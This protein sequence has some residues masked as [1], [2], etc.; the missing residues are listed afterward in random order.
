MCIRDSIEDALTRATEPLAELV[1]KEV[2]SAESRADASARTATGNVSFQVAA[3]NGKTLD[4]AEAPEWLAD[5]LALPAAHVS[6]P[7]LEHIVWPAVRLAGSGLLL[8]PDTLSRISAVFRAVNTSTHDQANRPVALDEAQR[9]DARRAKEALGALRDAILPVDADAL[10]CD[11]FHHAPSQWSMWSLKFLGGP[12]A[13]ERAGQLLRRDSH[14]EPSDV[15]FAFISAMLRQRD[16]PRAWAHVLSV[17][18]LGRKKKDDW[19][20]YTVRDIYQDLEERHGWSVRRADANLAPPFGLEADGAARF[21]YG[22]RVVTLRVDA[23]LQVIVSDDTGKVHASLPGARKG[24]DRARVALHKKRM[25]WM[26]GI[27]GRA[28]EEAKERF[29]DELCDTFSR[30]LGELR[31]HVLS[32]PWKQFFVRSLIWGSYDG[33]ELEHTFLCDAD[34]SLMGADF[35]T[36]ELPDD[37]IVRLV[38][39]SELTDDARR[40]WSQVLADSEILQ[41]FAQLQREVFT[42]QD[43]ASENDR[44]GASSLG[45][46]EATSK[47]LRDQ[48]RWEQIPTRHSTRYGSIWFA[49]RRFD[50]LGLCARLLFDERQWDFP[51]EGELERTPGLYVFRSASA[52]DPTDFSRVMLVDPSELPPRV[53]SEL[54]LE[55]RG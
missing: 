1:R 16:D 40:A 19:M 9:A 10:W 5:V 24:E 32:H 34:G 46:K 38:H 45:A 8:T 54:L 42:A 47:R 30:S 7:R 39:P 35:G 13:F 53:T 26:R 44:F 2:L 21:D 11:L 37:A 31:E 41:P 36:L 52:K 55:L 27:L 48:P 3:A 22:G 12:R 15:G 28:I 18:R 33:L 14:A 50:A 4:P 29:E 51:V 43:W 49:Q 25:K 23:S 20:G 6:D 17:E